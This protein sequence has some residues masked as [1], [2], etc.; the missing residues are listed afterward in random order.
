MGAVLALIGVLL[1]SAAA[2]ASL[3]AISALQWVELSLTLAK[4]VPT[5]IKLDANLLAILQSKDFQDM[6]KA[7]AAA[8]GDY[9]IR[10]Y[11]GNNNFSQ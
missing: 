1:G 10:V 5:V 3:G 4:G 6:V 11:P 7:N 2:P 9:V 8:N